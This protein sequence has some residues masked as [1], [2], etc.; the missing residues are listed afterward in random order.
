M[1][2]S[3]WRS[4][5]DRAC[6]ERGYRVT[7]RRG[8]RP[9]ARPSAGRRPSGRAETLRAAART[10]AGSAGA[11]PPCP[12]RAP[13]RR[14][15]RAATS[16]CRTHSARPGRSGRRH[17]SRTRGRRT[18]APRR[19]P[20]QSSGNRAAA[21]STR[22]TSSRGP[23]HDHPRAVE[24]LPARQAGHRRAADR[25]S[26]DRTRAGSRRCLRDARRCEGG[27][28]ESSIASAQPRIA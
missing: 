8:R 27:P 14:R 25:G 26:A 13:R 18:A 1:G 10:P 21:P 6:C 22:S 28:G 7:R 15:G 3:G 17:E 9:P 16:T 20:W 12:H 4:R 11:A 23:A 19:T 5:N 24:A 2:S